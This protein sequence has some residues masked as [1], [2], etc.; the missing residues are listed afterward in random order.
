MVERAN[1]EMKIQCVFGSILEF[2][3][4]PISKSA[5]NFGSVFQL[6]GMFLTV[7]VQRHGRIRSQVRKIK[8]SQTAV[9]A[10][11]IRLCLFTA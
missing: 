2:A 5:K 7:A 6:Q 3:S 10:L 1:R 4:W 11:T 8:W 9:S